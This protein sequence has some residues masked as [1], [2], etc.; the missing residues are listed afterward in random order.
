VIHGYIS[1]S[2]LISFLIVQSFANSDHPTVQFEGSMKEQLLHIEYHNW[3]KNI[4][5]IKEI[6]SVSTI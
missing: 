3:G 1:L 6:V 4:V 2:G 5:K